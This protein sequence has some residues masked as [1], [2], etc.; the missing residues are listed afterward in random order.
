MMSFFV[1]SVFP[2]AFTRAPGWAQPLVTSPLVLATLVALSFNLIFRIGVRRTVRLAIDPASADMKEIG[3]FIERN[4]GVWRAR[5]DVT[6]RVQFGIQ[7]FIEAVIDTCAP[8]GLI[9]LN[10]SYDE[11]SVAAAIDYTG[12]AFDLRMS[13]RRKRR[14]S[15]PSSARGGSPAISSATSPRRR[16]S[17]SRA[18]ATPCASSSISKNRGRYAGCASAA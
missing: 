7:Q 10:L 3:D 17:P 15:L 8:T 1:V 18:S 5:R 12:A 2:S 9:G 13:G 4:A 6:L 14:S 11:F 16:I